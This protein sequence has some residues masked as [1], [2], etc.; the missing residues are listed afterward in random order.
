MISLFLKRDPRIEPGSP[1]LQI[2]YQ[3]GYQGSPKSWRI[4]SK[5][6]FAYSYCKFLFFRVFL[7]VP[8]FYKSVVFDPNIM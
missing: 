2:L 4:A 8:I 3:L 7:Y 1:T 5:F 6:F